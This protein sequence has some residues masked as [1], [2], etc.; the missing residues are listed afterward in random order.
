MIFAF[1]RP[2]V[3]LSLLFATSAR[4]A[5]IY[6]ITN[7]SGSISGW[8][9]STSNGTTIGERYDQQLSPDNGHAIATSLNY[10][11]ISEA[12]LSVSSLENVISFAAM[13]HGLAGPLGTSS[14]VRADV[15]LRVDFTLNE[16]AL[17]QVIFDLVEVRP[18]YPSLYAFQT[19][20][21]GVAF[22]GLDQMLDGVRKT[23]YDVTANMYTYNDGVDRYGYDDGMFSQQMLLPGT[24]QLKVMGSAM[25]ASSLA[26]GA[27]NFVPVP[28]P[29]SALLLVLG[30]A[31]LGR[32]RVCR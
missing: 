32:R 26:D 13:A 20:E 9:Y 18:G 14:N 4:C 21:T 24:Y 28:E 16:A 7:I 10:G 6:D 15:D 1:L 22:I 27:M 29:T 17:L 30:L 12:S 23:V 31:V 3:V 19:S 25:R 8:A 11:A 2:A 5:H